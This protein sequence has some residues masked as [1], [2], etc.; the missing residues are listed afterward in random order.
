MSINKT[1]PSHPSLY[2]QYFT[3]AERCDLDGIPELLEPCQRV[4]GDPGEA[5]AARLRAGRAPCWRHVAASAA[6]PR[7]GEVHGAELVTA[8]ALRAP[9]LLLPEFHTLVTPAVPLFR[10]VPAIS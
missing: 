8:S 3:A 4:G 5:P 6:G 9:A 10:G 1:P 2:R 7:A